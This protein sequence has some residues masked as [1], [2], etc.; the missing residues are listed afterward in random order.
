MFEKWKKTKLQK[1]A[2]KK[3]KK[4]RS[5]WQTQLIVGVSLVVLIGILVTTVWHVTRI[6]S[7]QITKIEVHGGFTIPHSKIKELA[8]QTLQ[9]TYFKL[10]P[11]SFRLLYPKR[12]II[13]SVE[14]LPRLKNIEIDVVDTQTLVIFF[15]EYTPEALWCMDYESK[16]CLFLDSTGY[17]FAEAP[18]LNGGAFI[19]YVDS[20][21]VPEI[22]K[23]GFSREFIKETQLFSELLAEELDLYVIYIERVENLDILYTVSGGGILKVSQSMASADSFENLRSILGSEDF[24]HLQNGA[25]Q[26]IDLRFGD[27][28][29]LNEE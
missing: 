7:A 24:I 14:S 28:I 23:S 17:S 20:G 26:Y 13:N 4:E 18:A 25:F 2:I 22:K 21:I 9:G 16:S 3:T 11:R 5:M 12:D 29:F 1:R 27:K 8:T 10:I 6:Q 15:E 19:R